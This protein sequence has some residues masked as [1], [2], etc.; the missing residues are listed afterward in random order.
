MLTGRA[1][2]CVTGRYVVFARRTDKQSD[3]K[4]GFFKLGAEVVMSKCSG[5]TWS[6]KRLLGVG[7][8][9]LVTVASMSGQPTLGPPLFQVTWAAAAGPVEGGVEVFDP[10]PVCVST[11]TNGYPNPTIGKVRP[12]GHP[13]DP[14]CTG[15]MQGSVLSMNNPVVVNLDPYGNLLTGTA[16]ATAQVGKVTATATISY[17]FDYQNDLT[18]LGTTA[19][20][21]QENLQASVPAGSYLQ[22]QLSIDAQVASSPGSGG[23]VAIY[24]VSDD[25]KK[26]VI[27]SYA[28]SSTGK[29]SVTTAPLL[30]GPSGTYSIYEVV[31]A[32]VYDTTGT[33]TITLNSPS[34]QV[35]VSNSGGS[36]VGQWIN[37]IVDGSAWDHHSVLPSTDNPIDIGANV[38]RSNDPDGN[39]IVGFTYNRPP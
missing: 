6:P 5:I 24:M 1:T 28:V 7:V 33:T 3:V 37:G 32:N 26:I 16:S 20:Y 17:W 13:G 36:D 39:E 21:Y 23:A 31:S 11:N 19:T 25:L 14:P 2:R 18:D 38:T 12:G 9:V 15:C 8:V 27:N 22:L 35:L 30:I 29:Q 4:G 34:D 10:N